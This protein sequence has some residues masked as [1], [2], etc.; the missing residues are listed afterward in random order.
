MQVETEAT[1]NCYFTKRIKELGEILGPTT[2]YEPSG[3]SYSSGQLSTGIH[4]FT[5]SA[6]AL[7]LSQ[8]LFYLIV[9]STYAI[10]YIYK[11]QVP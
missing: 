1:A 3:A 2:K 5:F 9:D 10:Y 8:S 7:G 11:I 6:S 4:V